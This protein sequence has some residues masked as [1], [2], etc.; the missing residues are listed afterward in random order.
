MQISSPGKV[1]TRAPAA[2]K[3]AWVTG[4]P[5]TITHWR[6]ASAHH[7]APGFDEK[8]D[9]AGGEWRVEKQRLSWEIL[10]AF[11]AAAQQ[12]GIPATDDFNRGSKRFGEDRFQ[13]V[14]SLRDHVKILP[15]KRDIFRKCA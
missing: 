5:A 6:G 7:A 10:D 9:R 11:A 3:R 8:G 13:K 1:H 14:E 2:S 4:L 15:G 12:A